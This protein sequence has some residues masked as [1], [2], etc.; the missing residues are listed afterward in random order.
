MAC[1]GRSRISRGRGPYG[2]RGPPTRVFFGKNVCENESPVG[3]VR[4][5]RPPPPRSANGLYGEPRGIAIPNPLGKNS[6][7]T[8]AALQCANFGI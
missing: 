3:G 7:G 4:P 2:G 1:T 5:A 8:S 6:S